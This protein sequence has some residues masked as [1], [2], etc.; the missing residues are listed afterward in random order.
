MCSKKKMMKADSSKKKE[1][2]KIQLNELIH[3]STLDSGQFGP[4]YLVKA[5]HNHQY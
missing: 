2:Q 5:K 3:I 1:A 4:V